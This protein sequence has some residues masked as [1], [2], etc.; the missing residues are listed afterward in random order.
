MNKKI[1][2]IPIAVIIVILTGSFLLDT[3]TKNENQVFFHATLADPAL[4]ENGIYTSIFTINSGE[5]YFRFVPN[6]SSPEI[7]SITMK[8]KDFNF[9]ENFELKGTP[10]QTGISEYFTWEYL[11]EKTFA[12]DQ[13]QE[14]LIT[15]NPNG[16]IMGS[17]SVDILEN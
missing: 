16:K 2:I 15:I 12:V 6:G 13:T 17:V 10:H 1:V 5:Y 3:P 11:G 7:L 9:D 14:I 4:Y 8:G